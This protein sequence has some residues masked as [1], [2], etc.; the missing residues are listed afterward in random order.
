[1]IKISGGYLKGR[2]IGSPA[3]GKGVR[4]T[5]QKV[6]LAL[7]SM[8]GDAVVDSR[9]LDLYSCT[10]ALGIEAISRGALKCDFVERVGRNCR[11]IADNL[12]IMG[13]DGVGEV[14]RGESFKF[15]E[16]SE[17]G[18]DMVF[19]D[20]PFEL[21]DWDRVM[22][23]VG[24]SGFVNKGGRVVAEHRSNMDLDSFYGNMNRINNKSYGDSKITIYEV[25]SG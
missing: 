1:V 23:E 3:R 4:P 16:Q 13:L 5:T 24:K 2:S 22:C 7:F 11:L 6:K 9:V 10:G 8:L 15:V 14:H 20:P 19:L 21:D 18:Y 12:K 17:G 25:V